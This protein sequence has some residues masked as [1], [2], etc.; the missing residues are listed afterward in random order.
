[1]HALHSTLIILEKINMGGVEVLAGTESGSLGILD[2]NM[3]VLFATAFGDR[4]D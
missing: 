4:V 3:P 1:M 2:L